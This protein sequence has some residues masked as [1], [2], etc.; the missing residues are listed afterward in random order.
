MNQ[1]KWDRYYLGMARAAASRSKDP[2]TKCGA[3]IVGPD[4]VVASTG[5][6]GFPRG[7]ADTD[8]RLEDREKKYKLVLHAEV[9]AILFARRD[10]RGHTLYVW[11]MMPCN[12]CALLVI[13]TGVTRVVSVQDDRRRYLR[14][15]AAHSETAELFA[16]AGVNLDLYSRNERRIL[17]DDHGSV[18]PEECLICGGRLIIERP[19]EVSCP[20]CRGEIKYR[21]SIL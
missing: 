18:W 16:E 6:N 8:E 20:T 13:Q 14:W 9:N 12:A 19:G 7:I 1:E 4:N 2:S 15:A 11:P 5:F 3:V 17:E 10:L 21:E